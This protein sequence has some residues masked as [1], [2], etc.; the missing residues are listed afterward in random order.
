MVEPAAEP[1]NDEDVGESTGNLK[2]PKATASDA[3]KRA[4]VLWGIG[5]ELYTAP[6]I[7]FTKPVKRVTVKSIAYD[8]DVLR[9]FRRIVIADEDVRLQA[10]PFGRDVSTVRADDGSVRYFADKSGMLYV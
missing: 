9:L 3:L 1:A 2:G 10:E 5:R 6:Q 8:E 4:A 7:G